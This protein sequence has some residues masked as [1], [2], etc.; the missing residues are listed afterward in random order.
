MTE[1][2]KE[3]VQKL[4]YAVSPLSLSLAIGSTAPSSEGAGKETRFAQR[5]KISQKHS[6]YPPFKH[7]HTNFPY[8]LQNLLTQAFV[9]ATITKKVNIV[10][11]T[12]G[13]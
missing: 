11:P 2:E 8:F 6:I 1:G 5:I 10:V 13:E 3:Q 7:K 12:G 4:N 9:C